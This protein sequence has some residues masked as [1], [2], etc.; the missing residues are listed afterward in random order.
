MAAQQV[1]IPITN[2][3]YAAEMLQLTLQGN[4]T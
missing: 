3:D 1:F 4:L 2:A